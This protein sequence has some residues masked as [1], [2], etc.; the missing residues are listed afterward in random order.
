MIHAFQTSI[1]D[2]AER[3]PGDQVF[4]VNIQLFPL[5]DEKKRKAE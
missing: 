5:T 3:H 2:E 4:Q 1:L